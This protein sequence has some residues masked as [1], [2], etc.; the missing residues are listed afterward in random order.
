MQRTPI[1]KSKHTFV[2]VLGDEKSKPSNVYLCSYP[3]H[4]AVTQP[5]V[6]VLFLVAVSPWARLW[7]RF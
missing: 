2:A 6:T 7:L 5:R 4:L 3:K 1:T